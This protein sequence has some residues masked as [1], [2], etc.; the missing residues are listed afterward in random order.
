MIR[1]TGALTLYLWMGMAGFAAA[2]EY[3]VAPR[4]DGR[5]RDPGTLQ[6]PWAT[7]K[8]AADKV[9]AGD[10]IWVRAGRF[11]GAQFTTSGSAESPIQLKA[12]P[13]EE[14]RI[15]A[16]NSSTP[17]G[18]NLEGV[19]YMVVEDLIVEGRSRAGIRAV[20][21]KHVTLR[22]NRLDANGKWGIFTGFC[23][24]LL[25]ENNQASNSRVQHGI[26]VSNSGDRPVIRGNRIWGNKKA[27]IHMNGDAHAGGDGI[28]SGAVVDGNIIFD[29]GEGG[30]SGINMDGVQDSLIRNNLLF[31]NHASGISVY[32]IDGGGPSTG[33]RI[34]NNTVLVA[35]DG[36]WA[37]NIRDGSSGNEVRNCVFYN[38]HRWRGSMHVATD[39]L[40]EFSS[41]NNAVMDRF[42]VD[43]GDTVLSLAEWQ[44]L[45]GQDQNSFVSTPAELFVDPAADVFHNREGSPTLDSGEILAVVPTDLEGT[46][47]PIG[48]AHDIGAYEGIPPA[49][50]GSTR[51]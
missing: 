48:L 15:T 42:T 4:P 40:A 35:S 23:D 7:L 41:E 6:A 28:I 44:R 29:N 27:G 22:G 8:H 3:Y 33:N 51:P 18:I 46:P 37:L 10:T 9:Q 50:S 32:R 39:S 26:Y 25:I 21:C 19:S 2:A 34:Y 31:D 11:A 12:Y 45:T 13:G 49:D 30:A 36:R 38:Y 24:D 14:V 43:D 16:D 47:R 1:I 5:D 20:K 17:D